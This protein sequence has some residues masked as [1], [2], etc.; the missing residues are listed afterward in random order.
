MGPSPRSCFV[1]PVSH[2]VRRVA[3]AI[4][5]HPLFE[6]L[7]LALI[8]GSSVLLAM[9]DP[10]WDAT[11]QWLS[12]TDLVRTL[13]PYTLHPTPYTLHPTPYT[14]HPTPYTLHL[15]PYTLHL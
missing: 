6:G 5:S 13:K 7:I 3:T 10:K 2:P 14:L 11:P 1:F 4:V 12:Y 9:E 8:L 15:A